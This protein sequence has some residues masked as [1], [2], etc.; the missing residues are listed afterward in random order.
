MI[1]IGIVGCGYVSDLY[2][3]NSRSYS[4]LRIKGAFD[5]NPLNRERFCQY[6][7]VTPHQTMESLLEDQSIQ[8]ILN[9]TNP[10]S[11]YAVS[12]S[13]LDA[14]KHVYTE[15][16]VDIDISQAKNL[17]NY[18]NTKGL[19]IGCAPCNLLGNTVQTVWKAVNEGQIGKVRL[20]YANYDDGMIAPQMRP[21]EWHNSFGV[22][23]PAKDEFE[24]GCTY[25]HAAY[26]LSCLNAIF[27]PAR[28]V[29]S[30]SSCQIPD[31]GIVV[32]SMAPDFSV[33]CIEYDDGVVAR[34]TCGLVAPQDKSLLIV[35]DDGYL[36]VRYLRNDTEPVFLRRNT[37]PVNVK[38]VENMVNRIRSKLKNFEQFIPWPIDEFQ[39]YERLP[40]A[41]PQSIV[42]A[43]V[44]KRV[45]FMLGPN[46]MANAILEGRNHRLSGD[47]GIHL[48]EQIEALQHPERFNYKRKIETTFLPIEPLP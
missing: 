43:S 33:G 41:L 46:E 27:G 19:R 31:K 1:N 16:P 10:R 42:Q 17:V 32:E 21:W 28:C 45:D 30:F 4:N 18:A 36:F 13:C 25:E 26:F 38:R 35:G 39:I 47:F 20:I 23:W 14:G 44:D 3:K 48:L 9:L 2:A 6:H 29:T 22:P 5:L 7:G 8:L 37:I 12:K 24:V 40:F 11:H 34:V 15:K